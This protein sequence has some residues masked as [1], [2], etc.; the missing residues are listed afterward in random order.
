MTDSQEE[1]HHNY[2]NFTLISSKRCE[3]LVGIYRLGHA[4]AP[5]DYRSN[6]FTKLVSISE[7][8]KPKGYWWK[9]PMKKRRG[10]KQCRSSPL[11]ALPSE[12]L[13]LVLCQLTS[14]GDIMSLGSTS[15][16]FARLIFPRYAPSSLSPGSWANQPVTAFFCDPRKRHQRTSSSLSFSGLPT[17]KTICNAYS[18]RSSEWDISIYDTSEREGDSRYLICKHPSG[19]DSDAN[20]PSLPR[21]SQTAPLERAL[22]RLCVPDFQTSWGID[23]V[24]RNQSRRRYVRLKLTQHWKQDPIPKVVVDGKVGAPLDMVLI[25]CTHSGIPESHGPVGKWCN[26]SFDIVPN[27]KSQRQHLKAYE[28]EDVTDDILTT[29]PGLEGLPIPK[30]YMQVWTR[31][32]FFQKHRLF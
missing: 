15:S 16:T 9:W 10:V 1:S 14:F 6:V 11:E 18:L 7:I 19:F 3:A 12:L 22:Y 29:G 17:A 25:L 28:W 13:E 2:D 4:R 24:L 21:R 32:T 20:S 30:G 26:D 23:W 8:T 31:Q 27:T 5:L